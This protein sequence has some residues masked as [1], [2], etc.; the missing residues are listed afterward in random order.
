MVMYFCVVDEAGKQVKSAVRIKNASKSHVA[1]KVF[2]ATT[3]S[4]YFLLNLFVCCNK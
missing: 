2:C 1:F 3:Y 4:C